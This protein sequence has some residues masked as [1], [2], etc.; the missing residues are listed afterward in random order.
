VVWP[1]KPVPSRRSNEATQAS[2]EIE[3]RPLDRTDSQG[4]CEVTVGVDSVLGWRDEGKQLAFDGPERMAIPP[5][6]R[7]TTEELMPR[8]RVSR[9]AATDGVPRI[10]GDRPIVPATLRVQAIETDMQK[11]VAKRMDER[12]G[13][14]PGG[15]RY[16]HRRQVPR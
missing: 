3:G 11:I 7:T 16:E 9:S 14:G 1:R 12:L 13:C 8:Q 6:T 5:E 4:T 15:L 2:V 10:T